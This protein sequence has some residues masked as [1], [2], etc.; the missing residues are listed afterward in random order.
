MP[1]TINQ[2]GRIPCELFPIKE[3]DALQKSCRFSEKD[4]PTAD[5][6]GGLAVI[7]V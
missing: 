5:D 6:A 3:L 7:D 4:Y 2:H 1:L